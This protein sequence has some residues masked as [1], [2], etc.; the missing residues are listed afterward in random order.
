MEYKELVDAVIV[1]QLGVL[2]KK[3]LTEVLKKIAMPVSKDFKFEPEGESGTINDLER[4]MKELKK[5]YGAIAVLGCKISIG[6]LARDSN[7]KLPP[8]LR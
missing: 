2:G 5:S 8:I 4:L 7:L 3:R 1:R 6:R